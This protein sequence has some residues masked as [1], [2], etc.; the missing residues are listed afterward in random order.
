MFS[1]W[2]PA[3]TAVT[4][5]VTYTATFTATVNTY[6]VTWLDADGTVLETD[7]DVEYGTTPTYDG[8][9]P[10]KAPTAGH[11][12][13]FKGWTPEVTV[14]TGDATYTANFEETGSLTIRRDEP[15]EQDFLYTVRLGDKIVARVVLQKGMTEVT[16]VGL[17]P[18]T[19]TVT[20][21]TGWSWR[22]KPE[23]PIQSAAITEDEKA[24]VVTFRP[25]DEQPLE[26]AWVSSGSSRVKKYKVEKA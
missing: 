21:E 6:T 2:T 1:G 17:V 13:V 19:Y 8:K 3:A 11:S 16:V 4:S 10:A 24:A 7:M 18:G 22:C 25:A 12:Y 26:T 23:Q 15:A 9:T 5:N 14:V 20:E